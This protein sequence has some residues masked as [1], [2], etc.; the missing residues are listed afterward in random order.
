MG[1]ISLGDLAEQ[2]AIWEDTPT[3]EQYERILTGL[4]HTHLPK[5]VAAGVVCYDV[6]AESIELLEIADQM[7]PHLQLVAPTDLQ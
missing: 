5:L 7:L 2:I 1:A 6:E 4:H 3:Y